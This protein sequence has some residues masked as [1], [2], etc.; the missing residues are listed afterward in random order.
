M[1]IA[2][3]GCGILG[4]KI[5]GELAYHGHKVKIHDVNV[6]A[7][8]K[9]FAILEADKKSLIE[10]GLLYQKNF[11]GQVLCMSRLEETVCD[12]DIILEAVKEDLEIKRDLFER[13]SHLCKPDAIIASSSLRIKVDDI[14]SRT[15]HKHRTMGLRFLF[16]V[17]YI[18][19]VEITPTQY[20]AQ[21]AVQKVRAMLERMG[22]TLFFRSGAQPLVLSEEQR[23][24]RK[25]ARL[26]QLKSSSGISMMFEK[27]IPLLAHEGNSTSSHDQDTERSANQDKECAICFDNDRDCLLCPCH[28]MITC[29]EC[30]KMLLNRRDGCPICRKDIKEII[31]VFHS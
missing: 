5:A 2:V 11:V 3:I 23:E 7:L 9:V 14:V 25:I 12:A 31:K 27:K 16:P 22:K 29:H 24:E 18:P 15:E 10:D 21:A 1:R 30:S 17:Y 26:E 4:P 13:I 8:N 6:S 28:H 19:E 20:T